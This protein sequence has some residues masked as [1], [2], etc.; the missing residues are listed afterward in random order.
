MRQVVLD[1]ETTG[2]E[3]ELGHRVIEIGC[4]EIVG[5]GLGP[6]FQRYLN[7]ERKIEAGAM[8]VHRVTDEELRDKPL[9]AYVCDEFL[10]F[11]RGAQLIVHNAGFDLAFLDAEFARLNRGSFVR[12]S[13]CEICDTLELARNRHPGLQNNLDALCERYGV[14][15]SQRVAH[16]ALRD[17]ELLAK[18][19]LAM[20]R[21]QIG[22]GLD[23]A[24]RAA[25]ARDAEALAEGIATMVV[26]ASD[27]ELAEH[28]RFMQR[29]RETAH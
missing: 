7:P 5:R 29:L 3:P 23:R 28:E 11:V 24:A 17:A 9:F 14:D 21:G 2:L 15:N 27:E 19:Y 10:E 1:T 8:K 6:S 16:G 22:L 13:G 12:S 26:R 20:T 25:A 18:V 4:V